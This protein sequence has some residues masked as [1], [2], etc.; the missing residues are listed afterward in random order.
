[1]M[2]I[3]DDNGIPSEAAWVQM[4]LDCGGGPDCVVG[5]ECLETT[6][7]LFTGDVNNDG[8]ISSS[9]IIYAVGY[10]FKGGPEPTPCVAV[11]DVDCSGMIT[12]SDII[13]IVN[14]VFKSGPPFCDVC[15]LVPGTW[16]CDPS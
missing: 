3:V 13:E 9:D 6:N 12:S 14:Y 10:V 2:F 11:G 16:S 8:A 4:V 15:P 5:V 1:M 7:S